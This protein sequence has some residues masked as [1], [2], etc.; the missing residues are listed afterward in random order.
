MNF[1]ELGVEGLVRG[2]VSSLRKP[3]APWPFT[4]LP[5]TSPNGLVDSTPSAFEAMSAIESAVSAARVGAAGLHGGDEARLVG[6]DDELAVGRRR[7]PWR[8][9]PRRRPP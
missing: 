1:F 2:P 4:D 6:Q 8:S 9:R 3:K 5:A 7:R